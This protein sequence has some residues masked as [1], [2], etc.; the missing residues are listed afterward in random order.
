MS[1]EISHYNRN[2]LRL[3][4]ILINDQC[5]NKL[6]AYTRKA[7]LEQSNYSASKLNKIIPK[8]VKDGLIQEGLRSG[9][10]KTYFITTKGINLMNDHFCND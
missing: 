3:L 9:I 7:L 8:M 6:K 1:E 4:V 2:D 5:V 10:S